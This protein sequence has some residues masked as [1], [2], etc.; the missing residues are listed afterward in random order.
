[1]PVS[2]SLLMTGT[3]RMNSDRWD[4]H[5]LQLAALHACMSKD[6]STQVG[7]VIV[8]PEREVLSMGFNGLPRGLKDSPERLNDR[9]RKLRIIV[10]AEMNA[11]LQAA[12][13]GIPLKGST[14]Y[15]MA[16][17]AKTGFNWGG[18]PCTR[19][20]VE[21][22]QTGIAEIV[23]IPFR[24]DAAPRWASD[25]EEALELIGEAGIAYREIVG[26][27]PQVALL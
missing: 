4:S 16:K 5:F 14:I 10:H 17:D 3:T 27:E 18:P 20:T 24:R 23:T 12:R 19:C 25:L 8:G 6:P 2:A 26:Y 9:D 22:M 15:I 21:L 7:A 1:M 11:V 13:Y